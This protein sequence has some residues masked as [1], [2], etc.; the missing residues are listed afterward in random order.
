M[1]PPSSTGNGRMLIKAR[2]TLRMTLNHSTRRQPCSSCEQIVIN[3]DDHHRAAE[4]LHADF[5][6]ACANN[7]PMVAKI[8]PTLDWICSSGS[9]MNEHDVGVIL[10]RHDAERTDCCPSGW[11]GFT[12]SK[13]A[14]ELLVAAFH[15]QSD[16][17][18]RAVAH[19][20]FGGDNRPRAV[21]FLAVQWPQ[22]HRRCQTGRAPPGCCSPLHK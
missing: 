11:T 3:P 2:F 15:G 8:C 12:A 13:R 16:R 20:V 5:A 19:G 9:R 22:F 14:V 4:L 6:L 21:N 1:C 17:F 18:D 7:A 10:P